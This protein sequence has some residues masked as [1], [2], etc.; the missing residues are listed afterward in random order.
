MSTSIANGVPQRRVCTSAPWCLDPADAERT[1]CQENAV[2]NL[3]WNLSSHFE[4]DVRVDHRPR[5]REPS[6]L[7]EVINKGKREEKYKPF[8][9]S[10]SSS[11]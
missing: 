3:T 5:C 9:K 8:V 11:L 10:S 1:Q 7:L 2:V 6:R 4:K